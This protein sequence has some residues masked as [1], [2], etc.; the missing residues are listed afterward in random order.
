MKKG[1]RG[2]PDRLSMSLY[3]SAVAVDPPELECDCTAI[4]RAPDR[5]RRTEELIGRI[6]AIIDL[7]VGIVIDA[8]IELGRIAPTCCNGRHL[9]VVQLAD[10]V[11]VHVAGLVLELPAAADRQIVISGGLTVY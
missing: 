5:G 9:V 4:V 11:D 7:T 3:A 2:L 6:A 10:P 1:G 8:G